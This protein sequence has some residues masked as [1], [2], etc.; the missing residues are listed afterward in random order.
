[1]PLWHAPCNVLVLLIGH[2]NRQ[3]FEAREGHRPHAG[4]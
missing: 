3:P 2:P 1:L 4:G